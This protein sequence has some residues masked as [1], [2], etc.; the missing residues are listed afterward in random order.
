MKNSLLDQVSLKKITRD[1]WREISKLQVHKSQQEWVAEPTYY[2]C[3]CMYDKLWNPK[4]IYFEDTIV[5]FLMWAIDEG[6]SSYW[7]G[8]II[9]D[10]KYQRKGYGKAA[11]NKII[12]ELNKAK[13]AKSFALSFFPDNPASKLYKDI[14]FIEN[15]EYEDYELVARLRL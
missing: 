3:M 1:N 14:G 2:L 8:G 12:K 6:D 15:G 11:I 10:K 4:A 9:I 13:N 5:G 7:L